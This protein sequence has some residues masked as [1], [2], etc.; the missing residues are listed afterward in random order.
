MPTSRPIRKR[1]SPSLELL[2]PGGP[3]V[4]TAITPDG[5]AT[6]ETFFK[7]DAAAAWIVRQN[8]DRNIYVMVAEATG[9]LR[10][11]AEK[12]DVKCARHLW[13]DADGEGDLDSRMNGHVPPP[14]TIVASG[15]GFNVYWAL[16]EPLE[17]AAEIEAHN[18][19]LAR[20]LGADHCRNCDR[21]LRLPGTINWPNAKKKRQ[22]RVP[23]LARCIEHHPDRIY[24]AAEFGRAESNRCEE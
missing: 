3:W 12:S 17:D 22:G 2:R 19:W 16:A 1:R 20:K 18:R 10:K 14:S 9:T 7:P 23:V 8:A 6:T 21:I 4:L 24:D 15:G 5:P 11:K 13:A